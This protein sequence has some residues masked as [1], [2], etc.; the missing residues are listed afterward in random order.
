[1]IRISGLV[2]C[3]NR[4]AL[5]IACLRSLLQ[6]NLPQSATLRVVLVDDGSSDGT[7][8]AVRE[9]FPQVRIIQGSGNLFWCGG[10]RMAWREA[11]KDDPDYYL[12]FNDD[13]ALEEDAIVNLIELAGLPESRVIAVASIADSVT[14]EANYGGVSMRKG[15][16]SPADTEICDTFTANCVLVPRAVYKELGVF[17]DAYTHAMGDTDYGIQARRKGISILKSTRFLGTC[18][19]NPVENTWRDKSLPRKERLRLLQ[20]TKGL[21]FR[22]WLAFTQRNFG[23]RWP[24]YAV[25]PIL[26]ILAGK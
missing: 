23:F 5:T 3:H 4:K 12:L 10:M 16:L 17:H 21:P 22:E 25:A 15:I 2:T 1:M 8:D 11:A 19:S 13:T 14:R 20:T 7:S 26:R 18:G 6:Q 9:T 24:Y